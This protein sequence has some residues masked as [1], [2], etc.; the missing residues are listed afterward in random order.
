[1][2]ARRVDIESYRQEIT[3]QLQAGTSQQDICLFFHQQGVQLSL[4]TLQR[5]LTTWGLTSQSEIT[6]NLV[7][8]E[9]IVMRIHHLW[10]VELY[11]DARLW[12][13]CTM[14]ATHYRLDRLQIYAEEPAGTAEVFYLRKNKR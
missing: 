13:L 6:R 12:T 14:K 1:M 7:G 3:T 4:R 5:Y 11:D 2:P 9:E 8:Y 10:Q